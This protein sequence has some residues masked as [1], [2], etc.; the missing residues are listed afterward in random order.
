VLLYD[1]VLMGSLAVS[2]MP[3]GWLA[4]ALVA[5]PV[6]AARV[7]GV[8]ALEPDLYLLGPAG[9]YITATLGGAGAAA[10]LLGALLCWASLPTVGAM[11]TFRKPLRRMR[12]HANER[13]RAAAGERCAGDDDRLRVG[14][15]IAGIHG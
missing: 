12:S 13:N 6:D 3:A 10:M 4:A 5:N 8:L 7:L 14:E 15:R 1:L 2:G 11:V 9:A